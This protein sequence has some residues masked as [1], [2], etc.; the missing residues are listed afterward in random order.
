MVNSQ[1][2]R[3]FALFPQ[4][5]SIA[6]KTKHPV[7]IVFLVVVTCD[8]DIMPPHLFLHMASDPTGKTAS[9]LLIKSMAD[10]RSRLLTRLCPMPHKQNKFLVANTS[11]QTSN[12]LLLQLQSPSL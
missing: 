1:N 8:D 5:V 4:D 7:F 3:W 2:S 9:S 11:L 6:V 12:R 10:W